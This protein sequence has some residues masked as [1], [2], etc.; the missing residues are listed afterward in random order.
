MSVNVSLF[1]SDRCEVYSKVK[2]DQLSEILY[3]CCSGNRKMLK[4]QITCLMKVCY[5]PTILRCRRKCYVTAW[6]Q[7]GKTRACQTAETPERYQ[8]QVLLSSHV[9]EISVF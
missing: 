8:G 2:S 5:C 6:T 9:S 4:S 7:P 1:V 3:E